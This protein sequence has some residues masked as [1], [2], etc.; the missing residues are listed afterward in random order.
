MKRTERF[1]SFLFSL[2]TEEEEEEPRSMDEFFVVFGKFLSLFFWKKWTNARICGFRSLF[3]T[4]NPGRRLQ[5]EE[6][7][8]VLQK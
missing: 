2:F 5:K 7:L 6:D 4:H 3:G 8:C 1:S